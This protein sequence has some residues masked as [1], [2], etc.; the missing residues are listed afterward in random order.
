MHCKLFVKMHFHSFKQ[1]RGNDNP[2]NIPASSSTLKS[3][4]EKA[5]RN[6]FHNA[7]DLDHLLE[8]AT[9][10]QYSQEDKQMICTSCKDHPRFKP[11][12]YD[13]N[14]EDSQLVRQKKF[15]TL[16]Q[17]ML[18]HMYSTRMHAVSQESEASRTILTEN[19]NAGKKVLRTIYSKV[20]KG[21]SYNSVET[22]LAVRSADGTEMGN[23]NHSR[24]FATT[25][26][27]PFYE[28]VKK[29]VVKSMIDPLPGTGRPPP[30]TLV[31]DKATPCGD[32]LQIIGIITPRPDT[33]ELHAVMLAVKPVQ[34]GS[35]AGTAKELS[36]TL[37]D[38]VSP[39][40]I[41]ER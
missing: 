1:E 8:V 13:E 6:G 12:N 32:T 24:N 28:A 31:A 21:G 5:T 29:T 23:I 38:F 26:T 39:D 40:Q 17:K 37:K 20:K 10:F 2:V 27:E 33:G 11:V 16:K 19:Y 25:M 7:R 36:D 9:D 22:E 18:D 30:F 34:H 4:S 41:K 35:G 3:E 14:P 15:R